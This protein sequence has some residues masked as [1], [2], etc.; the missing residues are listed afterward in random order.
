LAEQR[1]VLSQ[2]QP[3]IPGKPISH[4]QKELGLTHVIKMASN[5]N[6]LGCSPKATE[7][8]KRWAENM[9]LYPDGSCSELSE[10]LSSKL[11]VKQ[12][13][14]IFGAG[15]DQI[16]EM[17]AQAYINTGDE[18]IMPIPSF[19]RY[20]TVTRIMDGNPIEIKLNSDFRLDLAAY[21]DSIT[22]KTR[23]IWICNPNNPTG[24][25]ITSDEQRAFLDSVP[26]SILVVLDE[27]YF[28][29]AKGE[30]YPESIKL[31][32][33]HSNI[34]I[35]RTFSKA[36]GLAGLRVGYAISSPQIISN[37]NKVR[38]P[39]NVNAAA[40]SAALASIKDDEFLK[41]SIDNNRL[42]KLYLYEAFSDLG[43][44]HIPTN[45][46]FVMVKVNRN[47]QQVFNDLL[48]EGI[49]VRPGIPFMMPDWIRLTIGTPEENKL[50]IQALKKVLSL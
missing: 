26:E 48:R 10:A 9:A 16:V 29:Y 45:A 18:A 23:I 40:Q 22:E 5:E 20:E 39:F 27:A 44:S 28:E 12:E 50:F 37:L 15:S 36:F 46:N 21:A 33:S 41:L 17:I 31:L 30:N 24:T 32:E 42:G 7:A 2:I 11:G 13:Q 34:I 14:L 43:L 19:P 35:L 25:I 1:R 49:I 4:V 8:V 3:Y 38:A 47:S 6:P